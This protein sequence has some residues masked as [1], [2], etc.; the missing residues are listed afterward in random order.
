MR[1][2]V[3]GSRH[4]QDAELVLRK[5]TEYDPDVIIE[6]GASGADSLAVRAGIQLGIFVEQYHANWEKYGR[7]A[8]PLR[9]QEM[10]DRGKP[11]VVLAFPLK[12]SK[13][14][15]DMV[16]RAKDAGIPVEVVE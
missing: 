7:A 3:T 14:T 12:D 13:G 9:N 8:G 4:F 1:L 10:L 6:G 16:K 2:L 5:I 15:W 11:D